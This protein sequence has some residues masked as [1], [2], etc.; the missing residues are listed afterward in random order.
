MTPSSHSDRDGP[1]GLAPVR[2]LPQRQVP[3]RGSG[4]GPGPPRIA[5]DA[6]E[7]RRQH[8]LL[9]GQ[10]PF[11]VRGDEQPHLAERLLL[12]LLLPY[13]AYS[14]DQSPF[15]TFFSSLGSPEAGA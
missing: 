7:H 15:V 1:A 10:R 4:A 2:G 6:R 3:T 13:T 11:R 8:A 9:A 12:S 5:A 14:A